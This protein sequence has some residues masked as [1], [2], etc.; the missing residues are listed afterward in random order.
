MRNNQKCFSLL[1]LAILFTT[2]CGSKVPV[3]PSSP[4]LSLLSEDDEKRPGAGGP[5]R[6]ELSGALMMPLSWRRLAHQSLVLELPEAN[7]WCSVKHRGR[8][9][10]L[11]HQ[12]SGASL[13]VVRQKER[14]R[15]SF[16]ECRRKVVSSLRLFRQLNEPVQS[17]VWHGWDGL[18][19]KLEFYFNQ[20]SFIVAAVGVATSQCV[21]V[22]F[23]AGKAEFL[24]AKTA[25]FVSDILPSIH[26]EK[27]EE[28]ALNPQPI[29]AIDL[30]SPGVDCR[31]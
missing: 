27:I 23:D 21:G 25:A 14:R 15:V 2:A 4:A 20:R 11:V 7:R 13:L 6:K 10:E 30:E 28:A 3:E 18:T 9:S 22:V 12:P 17:R 24:S 1:L 5:E 19:G 26:R 16:Q 8:W 31:P 29:V